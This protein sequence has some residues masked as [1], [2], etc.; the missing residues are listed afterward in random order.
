MDLHPDPIRTTEHGQELLRTFLRKFQHV[1]GLSLPLLQYPKQRAPHLEVY[2]Y[3][4]FRY[5]LDEHG[6]QLEFDCVARPK[7]ERE[8]DLAIMDLACD[9]P[10]HVLSDADINKMH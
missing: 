1:S 9:K 3:V 6:C 5:F 8:N 10:K 4:Y 7:I 2:Y